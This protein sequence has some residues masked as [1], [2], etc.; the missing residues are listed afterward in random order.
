MNGQA[1]QALA[2]KIAKRDDAVRRLAAT[3]QAIER[4]QD[5]R[6][7][8]R[9]KHEAAKAAIEDAKAGE[10]ALI[11]NGE[12]GLIEWPLKQARQ[13]VEDAAD[14]VEAA[15]A[16]I[17]TLKAGIGEGER[18]VMYAEIG[19]DGAVGEVL[20]DA[21][22]KLAAEAEV[23]RVNLAEKRAILGLVSHSSPGREA[24]RTLA[25]LQLREPLDG[26]DVS[27]VLRLWKAAI[28]ALK[29]D[30]TTPLPS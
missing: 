27:T 9:A 5:I 3:H 26:V 16:A 1:R 7:E 10:A 12:T 4:A 21:V 24:A 22:S 29:R 23:L 14:D 11:M 13:A 8:A 6:R 17:E 30:A 25:R 28:E 15:S 20:A 2:S 18:A 19:V